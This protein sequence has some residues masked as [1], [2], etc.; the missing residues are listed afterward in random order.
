MVTRM[1]I[2]KTLRD[3]RNQWAQFL[4]V[5]VM[6]SLTMLVFVG[7]TSAGYGMQL[8]L[9]DYN[10][11]SAPADAWLTGKNITDAD[12]EAM[13]GM[14]T[15]SQADAGIT[16]SA[17]IKD[18]TTGHDRPSIELNAVDRADI[19]RL[20]HVKAPFS[21]PIGPRAWMMPASPGTSGW[22]PTWP[23]TTDGSRAT[24][25]TLTIRGH[26]SRWCVQGLVH[27]S[28]YLYPADP[29]TSVPDHGRFGFA[30]TS[31]G[32]LQAPQS[33]SFYSTVRLRLNESTSGDKNDR[34]RR[35]EDS[36]RTRLGDRF[37][38]FSSRGSRQQTNSLQSRIDKIVKILA[39]FSA[40]F[41]LV[42][43][44]TMLTSISRLVGVQ[45]LQI[46]GMRAQGISKGTIR[47]HY[48]VYGLLV[49]GLGAAL[50]FAAAPF[51]ISRV[52]LG[53]YEESY[54]LPSWQVSV[55]PVSWMVLTMLI[56]ISFLAAVVA[57]GSSLS[58]APVMELSD[59]SARSGSGN[60]RPMLEHW[61]S[62]RLR[63]PGNWRWTLRNMHQGKLRT[64]M[65]FLGSL[66]CMVLLCAGFGAQSVA[67]GMP[68]KLYGGQYTYQAK[69]TLDQNATGDETATKQ[70]EDRV[71]HAMNSN[72][73]A[74]SSGDDQDRQVQW[75]EERPMEYRDDTS[76]S[77]MLNVVGPGTFMTMYDNQGKEIDLDQGAVLTKQAA[78][79][80]HLEVGDVLSFRTSSGNGYLHIPI[81]AIAYAPVSQGLIISRN[82]WTGT[83]GQGFKPTAA[84]L[85]SGAEHRN[86]KDV[87]GV[88]RVTD[89]N[90]QKDGLTQSISSFAGIFALLKLAALAMGLIVLY[91]LG[92]LNYS[93]EER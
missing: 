7:I 88:L 15:V 91:N 20:D 46:A 67:Q 37:L 76:Q 82:T 56:T 81:R 16:T 10:V 9:D 50:G 59:T 18:A 83:L 24:R 74:A 12:L 3:I 33:A 77:A 8:S 41:A 61:F 29:D 55:R 89:F 17:S 49:C 57:C 34:L 60:P 42:A 26:D 35:L 79:A 43:L 21:G 6:A 58:R 23:A 38:G 1:L 53:I 28:E 85:G 31:M 32:S 30:Y 48:G 93:E 2:R 19:P 62:L 78:H 11:S 22:M 65:G 4:S 80:L 73:K 64:L 45:S 92:V 87:D 70:V 63:I 90:R 66:G 84:L 25:S 44:S 14:D 75:I 13:R 40:I 69:A 72:T 36:L 68:G 47:L 52:L 51:T 54:W 71:E 27:S 86:I 5:F 39:L